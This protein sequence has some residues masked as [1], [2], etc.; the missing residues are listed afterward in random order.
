MTRRMYRPPA[1]YRRLQQ[2]AIRGEE[3]MWKGLAALYGRPGN[4]EADK[5]RWAAEDRRR[6]IGTAFSER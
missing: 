6:R 1:D 4:A 5:A 3:D 2:A